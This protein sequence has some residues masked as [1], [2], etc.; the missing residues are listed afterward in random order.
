MLL[1]VVFSLSSIGN[2]SEK[3]EKINEKD[4]KDD[5]LSQSYH[6]P[7]KSQATEEQGID[8][9]LNQQHNSLGKFVPLKNAVD[10]KVLVNKGVNDKKKEVKIG[11]KLGVVQEEVQKEADK[12]TNDS[13]V[14]NECFLKC[15][16]E[17]KLSQTKN[18]KSPHLRA[19]RMDQ[20]I[21]PCKE[22]GAWPVNGF[23]RT[24]CSLSGCEQIF[25]AYK[26]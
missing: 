26:D 24:H 12:K 14:D 4:S 19:K 7:L 21:P 1:L 16:C 25:V 23:C 22:C 20:P 17:S 15:C 6:G 11:N 5:G 18:P 10:M 2:C 8:T 3:I 9:N 13:N